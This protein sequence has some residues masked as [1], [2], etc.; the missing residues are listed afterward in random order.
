[1]RVLLVT[2]SFPPMVCG[3]GDYTE[4]LAGA[5]AGRAGTEVAV[6]TSSGAESGGGK[7]YQVFPVIEEWSPAEFGKVRDIVRSWRPDVIHI[8]YPT[9][10]YKGSLARKLP[11]Y[12]L[13]LWVPVIQTWHE[14]LPPDTRFTRRE[15]TRAVRPGGVIVV[16]PDYRQHLPWWYRLLMVHRRME[17]IPNAPTIPR[18]VLS[19]AERAEVRRRYAPEGKALLVFFGFL[20][21][22]KGI[23]DL[24]RILDPARHHLV[25]A[26]DVKDWDPYQVGLLRR[27]R[28]PPLAGQVSVTGF[29]PS[30][31]VA[32][33]LAAADA[34]VLP[35]R[36]GGG[37]WNTSLKA[38]MLQGTFILTTSTG[39]HG[40][41]AAENVYYARPGDLED[42]GEALARHVGQRNVGDPEKLVPTWPSIAERHL[43]FYARYHR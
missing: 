4:A 26:G 42:L 7:P 35:Y 20:F 29:L 11:V 17:L 3:V 41:D 32:R 8:Q 12:L 30:A 28:A 1:V 19:D 24:F 9:Q 15:L 38:A 27:V 25:L 16:R 22:H 5:L 39:R 33:L 34:I 18:A 2:G 31:E 43:T 23:D 6:L 40:Y 37:D 36:G 13:R 21:E 14:Y 10:G